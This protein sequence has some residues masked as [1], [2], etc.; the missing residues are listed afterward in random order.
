MSLT[1]F[2]GDTFKVL[3]HKDTGIML[4]FEIYNASGEMVNTIKVNDIKINSIFTTSDNGKLKIKIPKNYKELKH[5]L[6]N[7]K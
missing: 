7:K 3:V 4:D 2:D 1:S 6:P 5:E